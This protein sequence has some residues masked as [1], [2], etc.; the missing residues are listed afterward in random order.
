LVHDA[1]RRSVNAATAKR[2]TIG[3]HGRGRGR[4]VCQATMRQSRMRCGHPEMAQRSARLVG[5]AVLL[6]L[7]L[8]QGQEKGRL[9]RFRP[10]GSAKPALSPG[11]VKKPPFLLI[12][13]RPSKERG[14]QA[15]LAQL[16]GDLTC[17]RSGPTPHVRPPPHAARLWRDLY[18]PELTI[19]T[20][21]A[22]NVFHRPKLP[23][24][25]AVAL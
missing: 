13:N 24:F 8:Q 4:A 19:I 15:I 12:G 6:R 3:S 25:H 21:L 18:C 5:N 17:A 1:A 10:P 22:A 16:E 23:T 14:R 20:K 7:L 9:K 2:R 11:A